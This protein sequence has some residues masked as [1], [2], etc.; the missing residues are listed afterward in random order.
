M[1][2]LFKLVSGNKH[3]RI[4]VYPVQAGREIL[5]EA[6]VRTL[7]ILSGAIHA[8]QTQSIVACPAGTSAYPEGSAS[9]DDVLDVIAECSGIGS[10]PSS[11]LGNGGDLGEYVQVEP[12]MG[13]VKE[14]G[15]GEG[16]D[17][18]PSARPERSRDNPSPKGRRAREFDARKERAAER[19]AKSERLKRQQEL[20]RLKRAKMEEDGMMKQ[21][22]E[23]LSMQAEDD[24]CSAVD[25]HIR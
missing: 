23:C 4:I 5:Q 1:D 17:G 25:K 3:R 13:R 2:S 22:Q 11:L 15:R 7:E 21:Q 6:P 8:A 16:M 14:T 20:N 18:S 19:K 12:S 9:E 24:R 10:P